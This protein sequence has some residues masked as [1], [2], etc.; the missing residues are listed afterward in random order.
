MAPEGF[1]VAHPSS[2]LDETFPPESVDAN[3]RVFSSMFRLHQARVA[4]NSKMAADCRPTHLEGFG[5]RSRAPRLASQEINHS[6]TSGVR[7]GGQRPIEVTHDEGFGPGFRRR[8][9]NHQ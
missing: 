5:E 7:Q 1:H 2:Q 8:W 3:P 6:P 4:E 9:L